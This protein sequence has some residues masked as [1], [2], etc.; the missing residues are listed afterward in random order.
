MVNRWRATACL[1]LAL[2]SVSL[3]SA[4][5]KK[6]YE[7]KVRDDGTSFR[8]SVYELYN[9]TA[10]GNYNNILFAGALGDN[11]VVVNCV[12]G[13]IITEYVDK[14][15]SVYDSFTLD[16]EN[17][18]SFCI[19]DGVLYLING[20]S[21]YRYDPDNKSLDVLADD[22]ITD[23]YKFYPV[24][25]GFIAA[26]CDEVVLYSDDFEVLKRIE[27]E[28][29]PS[30]YHPIM[31]RDGKYYAVEDR[32]PGVGIYRIDPEEC[33][34]ELVC[35]GD[36][37]G[38]K[39]SD[40]YGNYYL[41]E[42]KLIS[43]DIDSRTTNVIADLNNMIVP[44]AR[45]MKIR[46]REIF[47]SD[48][49]TFYMSYVYADGHYDIVRFDH[50]PSLDY[51]G[52]EKI[53][54][55]GYGTR[56][57][58]VL[59]NAVTRF[60]GSQDTYWAEVEDYGDNYP[61]ADSAEAQQRKMEIMSR[62][63]SE[64]MPDILY[65]NDNDYQY[66]G[67]NGQVIDMSGYITEDISGK[68]TDSVRNIMVKPGATY[69]VF[70][71]Y[72]L[73]GY[74]GKSSVW[75]TDNVSFM[76]AEKKA[77]ELNKK[78]YCQL[79]SYDIADMAVRYETEYL[80][81]NNCIPDVDMFNALL[82]HA[83]KF[84]LATDDAKTDSDTL[85]GFRDDQYLL[86][87]FFDWR[88]QTLCDMFYTLKEQAVYIGFPSLYGSCHAIEPYGSLAIS[89]DST[90]PDVCWELISTIFDDDTQKLAVSYEQYP[91][92]D[93]VLDDYLTS[94]VS[95]SGLYKDEYKSYIRETIESID[96]V[97]TWDWGMFCIFY[98]EMCAMD[99]EGKDIDHVAEVI[100]SRY[101]VYMKENY[102]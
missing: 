98:E 66:M 13:K 93:K 90:K 101:Q 60:N 75:G 88:P 22:L 72:T 8:S 24:N 33:S 18:H 53:R 67:R 40:F 51:S 32:F 82:K 94:V 6:G 14:D 7:N 17:E 96:T 2:C 16:D 100:S 3:A 26:C 35:T 86:A 46:D 47:V 71:S 27:T 64:G 12:E 23:I 91:V 61:Y 59:M 52:R 97:I 31:I 85:E 45:V 41:R 38:A 78:L 11:T 5:G 84:G 70:S 87:R 68:L 102:G 10:P 54:I 49:N 63:S 55:A 80:L 50:D 15:G 25:E 69:E 42:N 73:Q 9:E 39:Q 20:K 29:E 44:Q 99:N 1:M 58:F 83:V 28:F 95:S 4:C 89:S 43:V 34:Y 79:F 76:D 56:D 37:I 48:D 57:D 65:G 92:N 21:A 81:E 36:E 77:D 30:Y 62:Y 74:W 19:K